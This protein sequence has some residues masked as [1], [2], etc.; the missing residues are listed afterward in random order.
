M[1]PGVA[2]TGDAPAVKKPDATRRIAPARQTFCDFI[3]P[4]EKYSRPLRAARF[5]ADGTTAALQ[6]GLGRPP[7]ELLPGADSYR[8]SLAPA[9]HYAPGRMGGPPHSNAQKTGG[10]SKMWMD[11]LNEPRLRS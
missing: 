1:I 11:R 3:F 4:S 9:R 6:S 7:S 5:R 10:F 2:E 8:G